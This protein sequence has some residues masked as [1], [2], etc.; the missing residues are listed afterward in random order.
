MIDA[1]RIYGDEDGWH[2]QLEGELVPTLEALVPIL[3]GCLDVRVDP[4]LVDDALEHWR[5]H[6]AEG[7]AV[8]GEYVASGSL[9]YAEAHHR[10]DEHEGELELADAIRDRARDT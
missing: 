1:V 6:Q 10:D 4:Q 7:A 9:S 3:D 5:E 8:H 2:I